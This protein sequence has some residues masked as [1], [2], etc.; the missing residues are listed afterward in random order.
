MRTL[1]I[2]KLLAIATL[3]CGYFTSAAI[4]EELQDCNVPSYYISGDSTL[5]HVAVS[6][7]EHNSLRIIVV[8]TASSSLV[9][10]KGAASA[11]P[12][13]M[14]A[15][16]ERRLPTVAVDTKVILRPRQTAAQ[17]ASDMQKVASD[18]RPVL[19]I[20]QAG[21]VDAMRGID[22]DSFRFALD[23][24]VDTV[25]KAGADVI[26]MN[27]QFSPRTESV[28]ALGS[29]A[30]NMR[31]VSRERDIPLFDR[32][33]IMRHWNDIGTF[34]LAAATKD[35]KM[36]AQVHDCIGRALAS[37]IIDA[38]QLEAMENKASQ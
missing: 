27:M 14:Q 4:A 34:D 18:A 13:R 8:G 12:A 28:I 3:L 33:A 2:V 9:G 17:M 20:W 37:Q 6:A 7:K 11:Y 22:P 36:A 32:L 5:K 38:A 21:T 26:L 31:V 23:Q 35:T 15:A 24:G 1:A 29:Y 30:D 25:Q 19:V 16:L 10:P